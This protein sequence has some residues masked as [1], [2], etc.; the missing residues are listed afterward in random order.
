MISYNC[1]SLKRGVK[2][3]CVRRTQGALE[4][5]KKEASREKEQSM[6]VCDPVCMCIC[7]YVCKNRMYVCICKNIMYVCLCM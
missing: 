7:V 6:Y 1:A 3:R 5:R 2:G 4:R